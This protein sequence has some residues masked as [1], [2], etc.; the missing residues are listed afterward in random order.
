MKLKSAILLIIFAVFS[1]FPVFCNTF[2]TVLP[3]L[4][5]EEKTALIEGK[6]LQRF[7]NEGDNLMDLVPAGCFLENKVKNSMGNDTIA[8]VKLKYIPFQKKTQENTP[9]GNNI[10]DV[11]NTLCSFSTLTGLTYISAGKETPL[12]L[13]AYTIRDPSDNKSKVQ[14]LFFSNL[15]EPFT[16]YYYQKDNKFGGAVYSAEYSISESEICV[17]LSNYSK[18]KPS[19]PFTI[20]SGNFSYNIDVMETENGYLVACLS[21]VIGLTPF[22]KNLLIICILPDSLSR[23]L[24][25]LISWFEASLTNR[26]LPDA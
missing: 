6:I 4:T 18:M 11:L 22:A 16:G 23:R 15:P 25:S 17:E 14:D 3:N 2:D 21:R 13:D 26:S 24:D 8:V 12:I 10:I 1:T 19:V 20:P 5:A 7:L 9:E